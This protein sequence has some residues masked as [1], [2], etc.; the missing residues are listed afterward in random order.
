MAEAP[1]H[2]WR[3]YLLVAAIVAFLG[4]L[5]GF[6][7]NSQD[8]RQFGTSAILWLTRY[9][10]T[11]GGDLSYG[12]V[13]PLISIG[14]VATKRHELMRAQKST[15]WAGLIMII[16]SLLLH[17]LGVRTQ[18]TRVSILSMI[19]L[20]WSIPFYLYGWQIAK[21][22]LF[23]CAYLIFCIPPSLLDSLTVPL[24]IM[25]SVASEHILNGLGIPA[26]RQGTLIISS[27][28]GGF[29]LGVDDP[30]SGL[31]SLIAIAAL[32]AVYAHFMATPLWKKFVLFF[33]ALPLAIIG[34]VVRVI[35]I[36]V[37]AG[38][39]GQDRAMGFYHDYSGYVVFV[40]AVLLTI[41]VGRFLE[42][43]SN[44]RPLGWI[45]SHKDEA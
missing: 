12:W 27:T 38:L 2:K 13:I 33:S 9:W 21:I 16:V 28:P 39:L 4:Y 10:N 26:I 40:V 42:T 43:Y 19:C 8:V 44:R 31:R 22:L 34:N 15:H 23:P 20:L 24:R 1:L 17:W 7:G 29:R 36:A 3:S 25:T 11:P 30:C 35:T 37:V 18:Q 14:I 45:R 41:A 32:T 5:Y 6:N